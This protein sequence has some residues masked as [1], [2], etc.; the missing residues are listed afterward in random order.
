MSCCWICLD[1]GTHMNMHT[2]TWQS[3]LLHR[4]K[5]KTLTPLG[6][7]ETG[8]QGEHQ[9]Q[10]KG[11][12]CYFFPSPCTF[13]LN[14]ILTTLSS[15]PGKVISCL[16]LR[17]MNKQRSSTT[18]NMVFLTVLCPISSLTFDS[19]A[20]HSFDIEPP[21]F[22]ASLAKSWAFCHCR[23]YN[24][25]A[26]QWLSMLRAITLHDRPKSKNKPSE[27]SCQTWQSFGN[28]DTKSFHCT[29]MKQAFAKRWDEPVI[30]LILQL[31]FWRD[32]RNPWKSTPTFK[33]NPL[34]WPRYKF[35][36][37]MQV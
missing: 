25:S 20:H 1:L 3:I 18:I 8:V 27:V 35:R 5:Y 23:K 15:W 28:C 30:Q 24:R 32:C 2:H 37:Y 33:I 11:L 19:S 6:S 22:C 9:W 29:A 7:L 26:T 4:L 13:L 21:Q 14:L 17:I 31:S 34:L 16:F 10:N 36:K 12:P